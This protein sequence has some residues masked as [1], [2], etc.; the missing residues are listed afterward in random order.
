MGKEWKIG[1]TVVTERKFNSVGAY[2][3]SMQ[4]CIPGYEEIVKLST[5]RRFSVHFLGKQGPWIVN[6]CSSEDHRMGCLLMA[7]VIWVSM[8][9]FLVL[10]R[11]P[12]LE[13]YIFRKQLLWESKNNLVHIIESSYKCDVMIDTALSGMFHTLYL[14]KRDENLKKW[15]PY[16]MVPELFIIVYMNHVVWLWTEMLHKPY[17]EISWIENNKMSVCILICFVIGFVFALSVRNWSQSLLS[18]SMN[19]QNTYTN[20]QVRYS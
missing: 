10:Q 1:G 18:L 7:Y 13:T 2:F 6:Q 8:S 12:V 3:K 16:F 17:E 11:E 20:L 4:T 19:I 9:W 15:T 14:M 5:Q